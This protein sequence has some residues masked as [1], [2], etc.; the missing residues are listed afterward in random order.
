[1]ANIEDAI[2]DYTFQLLSIHQPATIAGTYDGENGTVTM[3]FV[4]DSNTYEGEFVYLGDSY[5]AFR[6]QVINTAGVL[7]AEHN[8]YMGI[9]SRQPFIDSVTE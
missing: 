5:N 8:T 3:T 9:P 7:V 2:L 4:G 6:E 1:M